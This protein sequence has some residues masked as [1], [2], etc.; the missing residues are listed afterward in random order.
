MKSIKTLLLLSLLATGALVN[1]QK[2]IVVSE[3]SVSFGKSKYPG[4]TVT[5]PEVNLEKT[6]KSWIKQLESGTKSKVVTENSEMT[7]FGAYLK[8]ISPNPVNIYSKFINQDSLLRLCVSLELK[9]DQYLEKSIG[10]AQVTLTKDFLKKFA[11]EEYTDLVKEQLQ[12]EE[13][14]LKELNNDLDKLENEKSRMQKTIQSSKTDIITEKDN[15]TLQ[16]GEVTK[17]TSE[18]TAQNNEISA[19]EEGAAKEGKVG[20]L[21]DLEKQKKKLLNT[22]ESSENKI[23]RANKAIEDCNRDIPVNETEQEE[24]RNKIA[25]QDAVVQRFTNKLNTVKAY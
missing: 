18:I 9:K 14:K 2:P 23:N 3:D 22:I 25:Q 8:N 11:K 12:A 15:I 7:I 1:A 19:M 24:V 17:V 21:K 10:D 6:Q 4:F 16:T 20:Y 13:K 5:I